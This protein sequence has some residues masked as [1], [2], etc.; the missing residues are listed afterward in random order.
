MKKVELVV[1]P[2]AGMC[3]RF[4]VLS[5]ACAVA[6]LLKEKI[7]GLDITVIHTWN[8]TEPVFGSEEQPHVVACKQSRFQDFRRGGDGTL[9]ECTPADN[10]TTGYDMI[11]TEWLP[12]DKPWGKYQTPRVSVVTRGPAAVVKHGGCEVWEALINFVVL[13]HQQQ[14]QQ[15]MK[16]L[17]ETSKSLPIFGGDDERFRRIRS[18]AY[19]SDLQLKTPLDAVDDGGRKKRTVAI[20]IRRGDLLWYFPDS[21]RSDDEIA[22]IIDAVVASDCTPIV[23]SS[24]QSINEKFAIFTTAPTASAT[25]TLDRATLDRA[26]A[27]WVLLTKCDAI[28]GT[29]NSSFAMEAACFSGV[30]FSQELRVESVKAVCSELSQLGADRW[31]AAAATSGGGGGGCFFLDIGCSKPFVLS[32][33][34]LLERRGWCGIGI[35]AVSDP[36]LWKARKHTVFVSACLGAEAGKDV[37]IIIPDDHEAFAGVCS[38]IERHKWVFSYGNPTRRTMQTQ[39][40]GDILRAHDVPNKRIDFISLDVEGSEWEIVRSFP[41]DEYT[42]KC[43]AVEHNFEEP[44]RTL[45]RT[46]L[47]ETHGFKFVCENQWDDWYFSDA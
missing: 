13:Q 22:K 45:I 10:L 33:T 23:V 47:T 15:S 7:S 34:L 31:A 25:T 35:D 44:K 32:N 17:V 5:S 30:P 3:N 40:I 38:L 1:S 6:R 19:H 11:Y 18:I 14:Q 39:C 16:V 42:V 8:G 12:S 24:D 41:F 2:Q 29:P 36:A 21:F 37:E 27:D 28:I 20:H 4:G 46:F 9:R 26:F 43:I